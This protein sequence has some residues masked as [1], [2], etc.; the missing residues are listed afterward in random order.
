[1]R[2]PHPS[3]RP[4]PGGLALMLTLLLA[5]PLARPAAAQPAGQPAAEEPAAPG[6]GDAR[7]SDLADQDRHDQ[8]AFDELTPHVREVT[9]RR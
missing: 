8:A 1:M 7:T 9:D 2:P 5:L 4:H 3:S 6:S